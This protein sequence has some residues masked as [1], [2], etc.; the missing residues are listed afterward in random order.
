MVSIMLSNLEVFKFKNRFRL[1]GFFATFSQE[2][3]RIEKI[4]IIL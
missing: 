4:L 1:P 3:K 2:K